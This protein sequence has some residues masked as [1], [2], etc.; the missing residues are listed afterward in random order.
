MRSTW[1]AVYN[2]R[3]TCEWRRV[4]VSRAI[5]CGS[6]V[7]SYELRLTC[8]RRTLHRPARICERDIHSA[9]DIDSRR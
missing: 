5:G 7:T 4:H 8:E 2:R 1:S 6:G 3:V 9:R